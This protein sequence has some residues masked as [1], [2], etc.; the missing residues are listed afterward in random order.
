MR[1]GIIGKT[2][3]EEVF[4]IARELCSWLQE[5]NI[6]VYVEKELGKEMGH[7][8]SIPPTELPELVDVVIVFG[9]DGTF[10][11]VAR[12]V[13]KYDIP[14]L[15][16]NLGGL[17]FLT[18]IAIRELYP[19]MER[20]ISGQYSVEK[21]EMLYATIHRGTVDRIGDYVVL[22][23]VVINKGAV[24]RMIDL[25]LYINGSHVANFRADGI[26]LS[27]PTGSTAYSLSAGGPIIY[28]TLPLTI[29]TPIC[30]HTLTNRPLVVSSETTIRIKVLSDTPD[31]YLTL[32][33]HVGV[34]LKMGDVVEVMKSDSSVKL[35]KSPF[36][37]YFEI[38]KTKLMWG[39]RYGAVEG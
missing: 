36:R 19:M 2:N 5:R 29:I 13:C 32:D 23:D 37:D 7:P 14:I 24:A 26:I 18:E 10:L 22:N 17:G 28:P 16:V 35:I 3:K 39:E 20:I 21:R 38:L 4:E 6:E 25:A 12:L 34:T 9:G 11:G 27:T 1:I 8:N 15:G 31:T 33:G 30:S